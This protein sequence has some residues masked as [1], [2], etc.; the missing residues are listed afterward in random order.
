MYIYI[1]LDAEAEPKP[2]T[3]HTI[4]LHRG[5]RAQ[6]DTLADAAELIAE[7]EEFRQRRPVWNHRGSRYLHK[8]FACR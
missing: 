6:L 3:C 7:L 1:A 4:K 2:R 5:P 8:K